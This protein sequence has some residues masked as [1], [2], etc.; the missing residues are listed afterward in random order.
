MSHY[1]K[2]LIPSQI[3]N[4]VRS[5]ITKNI[6][7]Q[8]ELLGLTNNSTKDSELHKA[9]LLI[10]QLKAELQAANYWW[11][12]FSWRYKSLCI[13]HFGPADSTTTPPSVIPESLMPEF[14]MGGKFPLNMSVMTIR[15]DRKTILSF[16]PIMK[17]IVI[18]KCY[19]KKNGLYM[20]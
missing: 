1:L 15:P 18:L 7:S 9:H 6:S 5:E 2:K 16:T 17:S 3:R 14:T 10:G 4:Y 8:L 11:T 13:E 20:G 12:L 19:A